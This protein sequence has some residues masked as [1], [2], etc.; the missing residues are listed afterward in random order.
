[1]GARFRSWWQY[2][3][4]HW[5]LTIGIIAALI[6]FILAVWWFGWDWTGFNG[7]YSQITTTSTSQ[8]TTTTTAK[9]PEKTLWDLL[10]L[11]IIPLVITIGGLWYSQVQKDIKRRA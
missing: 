6:A 3:R 10:Q 7:G 2:I 4:K 9:P 5:L 8:G 1:M 11:L